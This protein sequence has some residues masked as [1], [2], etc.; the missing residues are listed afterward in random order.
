MFI[1]NCFNL[2][3]FDNFFVSENYINL[4]HFLIRLRNIRNKKL[5]SFKI[6]EFERGSLKLQ[7]TFEFQIYRINANFTLKV[8]VQDKISNKQNIHIKNGDISIFYRK[9]RG[10]KYWGI[11]SNIKEFLREIYIS[12]DVIR[13]IYDST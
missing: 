1:R 4:E 2:R 3:N 7:K 10:I 5:Y 13:N 6:Y 8:I 11:I 9:N 12:S